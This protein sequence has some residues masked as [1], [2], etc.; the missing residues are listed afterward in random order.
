[1]VSLNKDNQTAIDYVTNFI[2]GQWL[3]NNSGGHEYSNIEYSNINKTQY[4]IFCLAEQEN[5]CCYCSK[6]IGNNSQT[7]L[8]H[9]I[10]RSIDTKGALQSYFDFSNI[11]ADNIVLQKGF[12]ES[13]VQ[14]TTPPFPHHIAYQNIVASCNEVTFKSSEDFTCCNRNREDY[15]IPPYNL[16]PNN[17]VYL[18][19]GTIYSNIDTNY[20]ELGIK[21]ESITRLNLNKQPLKNIRRI[22]FLLASSDVNINQLT[23]AITIENY[24]EIFTLYLRVNPRKVRSDNNLI[25]SFENETSWKV[26]MQ[27]K[28]FLNYFRTNNN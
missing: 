3:K 8:E 2:N 23:Q 10:P 14:Q 15:F 1:M 12:R 13:T 22:W 25:D 4:K 5:V 18:N 7:E 26:L 19:D 17:I 9:L 28:Y 11:L 27:Y 24:S 16:I 20:N 21:Y 6:E